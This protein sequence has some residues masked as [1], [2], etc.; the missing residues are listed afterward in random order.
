M[1]KRK[2][3]PQ[4]PV[5]RN[6]DQ[7]VYEPQKKI[8]STRAVLKD[9]YMYFQKT[10]VFAK[11]HPFLNKSATNDPHIQINLGFVYYNLG[12]SFWHGQQTWGRLHANIFNYNYFVISWLQIQLQLHFSWMYLITITITLQCNL[13]QLQL[14]F[15]VPC[16]KNSSL[17]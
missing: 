17:N 5:I 4:F 14:L 16:P 1:Q 13:L 15:I 9:S 12:M 7:Y 8:L 3:S 10:T 2:W 6:C 11:L